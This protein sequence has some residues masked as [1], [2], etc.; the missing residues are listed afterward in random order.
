MAR[1]KLKSAQPD[2][3]ANRY[4]D[5]AEALF[6]ELGY[7]GASI[8]AISARAGMN[9]A[10]V[11]YYWGTKEALFREVCVRRFGPIQAEQMRRF[12][13]CARAPKRS[14]K[15]ALEDILRALVEPPLFM[16]DERNAETTRLLYGRVLTDPSPTVLKVTAELFH[17]ASM[18]LL[19]LI[20]KRL[21]DLDDEAFYWRYTAALG[22]FV[23]TQGFGERV[24]YAAE[25]KETTEFKGLKM[26]W[27]HAADEIVGFML[28]GLT[29]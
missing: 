20:R 17:D 12:K 26:D 4:L 28:A 3:T 13:S 10:T 11:V 24:A 18:L 22:A 21:P 6:I 29:R 5:A 2:D 9:K 19:K 14:R 25:F 23:F 15:A 1:P 8:G 27:R 16:P 7:E